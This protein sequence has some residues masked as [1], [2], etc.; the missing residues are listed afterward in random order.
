MLGYSD[1]IFSAQRLAVHALRNSSPSKK[2]VV[3]APGGQWALGR[4]R[5][6]ITILT[7]K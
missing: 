6:S 2:R 1:L 7:G 5:I 3:I 4:P